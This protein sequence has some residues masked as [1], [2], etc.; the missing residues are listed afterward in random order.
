M[1]RTTAI[2]LSGLLVFLAP[3][4]FTKNRAF[5]D[6]AYKKV[7][8]QPTIVCSD[9]TTG[10]LIGTSSG[11]N[12][13]VSRGAE[14]LCT[15]NV[16]EGDNAAGSG[17]DA[18]DGNDTVTNEGTVA[19]DVS[20]GD[21]PTSAASAKQAG[22]TPGAMA[23]STDATGIHG[24]NGKDTIINDSVVSAHA[25]TTADLGDIFIILGGKDDIEETNA[26]SASATGIDS[27]NGKD[28]VTNNGIV[29]AAAEADLDA[30][31]V[32]I[33]LIDAAHADTSM[34]ANATASGLASGNGKD[35]LTNAGDIAVTATADMDVVSV[36]VDLIDAASAD[37]TIRPTASVVGIDASRAKD[38]VEILNTGI[39]TAE[40][41]AIVTDVGVTVTF[42]DVTIVDQKDSADAGTTLHARAE[43]I[44]SGNGK[45]SLTNEGTVNAIASS[46][47]TSVGV[48]IASEG[49]PGSTEDLIVHGRLADA[50]ITAHADALGMGGGSAKDDIT[51]SGTLVSRATSET[52]QVSAN[53]GIGIFD[54]KVPTPGLV[55]GSAATISNATSTGIA[56]GSGKDVVLQEGIM[57]VDAHA[58]AS[59]VTAS[60]NIAE[61]QVDFPGLKGKKSILPGSAAVVISD[62][63]T[64]AITNAVGI[65]G[66]MQEDNVTNSGTSTV[67]ATSET[68]ATSVSVSFGRGEEENIFIL[69][70]A[71]ARAET[72]SESMVRGIIRRRCDPA[73]AV[74]FQAHGWGRA[75]G[76]VLYRD[77][78]RN[79]LHRRRGERRNQEHRRPHRFRYG[80]RGRDQRVCGHPGQG[81][82]SFGSRRGSRA[83][84]DIG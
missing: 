45:D 39:L 30:T 66:G 43:G 58:T 7:K 21:A 15:V 37:T 64:V 44:R 5:A 16:P 68:N 54:F 28:D 22:P 75:H 55:L 20:S 51:N 14:L 38:D 69:E 10:G 27:G 6:C 76:Y 62:T 74:R 41:K 1:K 82:R 57:D 17:L 18:G 80:G 59:A 35:T 26:V 56:S 12:I 33:N 73:G 47:A 9:T 65:E 84:H 29:S 70:G 24:G 49:V 25:S 53:L 3:L 34:A 71:L 79:G 61:L 11:D 32:S 13:L 19:V 52:I 8:G 40:A 67:N 77:C 72:R 48:S 63:S 78:Q 83:F 31:S 36:E 42:V 23:A 60:A 4:V 81:K 46:E 2:I 50:S